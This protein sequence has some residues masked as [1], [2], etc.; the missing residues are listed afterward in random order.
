MQVLTHTKTL[1]RRK[2]ITTVR[3]VPYVYFTK[4]NN[5]I[6]LWGLSLFYG[7]RPFNNKMLLKPPL[8][9]VESQK[10]IIKI[11]APFR[12]VMR[13]K[14]PQEKEIHSLTE[15]SF[16]LTIN[17]STLKKMGPFLDQRPAHYILIY[18]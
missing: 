9:L 10:K 2:P 8:S 14:I 17:Y 4:Y 3:A 11:S 1:I 5:S 7:G 13:R 16:L 18:P 12:I 15:Q 6:Q